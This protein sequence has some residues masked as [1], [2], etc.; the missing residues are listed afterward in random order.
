MTQYIIIGLTMLALI[1]TM[2]AHAAEKPTT[3]HVG[4]CVVYLSVA[5]TDKAIT[6]EVWRLAGSNI[7][8]ARAFAELWKLGYDDAQGDM[9]TSYLI[10]GEQACRVLGMPDSMLLPI[11]S[12]VN[13]AVQTKQGPSTGIPLRRSPGIPDLSGY[14][15]ETRHSIELACI[16]E[17]GKGPVAYGACLN[18]Q[19]ASLQRSPG[20]PDLSGYD[21]ETRHSIELACISENG[22]GP[23]AYGRCLRKHVESLSSTLPKS[24]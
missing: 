18:Q 7:H 5:G 20:I 21:F 1:L 10:E 8:Q 2:P 9:R 16:S 19:I 13:P 24:H 12:K 3:R 15:F 17:N 23:V 14:D 22:K 4:V 6:D 11:R